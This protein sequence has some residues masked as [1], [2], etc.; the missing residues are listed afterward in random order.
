MEN[1]CVKESFSSKEF[2]D[3][4]IEIYNKK[5]NRKDA[6]RKLTRSYLCRKCNTYHLTSQE[7]NYQTALYKV[8]KEL[9]E[10]KLLL[11]KREKELFQRINEIK[12]LKN[13]KK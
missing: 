1:K 4:A 2:A 3:K 13:K 6:K 11:A 9:H 10:T 12:K 8:R 5:Y 7:D